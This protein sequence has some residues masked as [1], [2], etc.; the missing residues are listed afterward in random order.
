MNQPPN[1]SDMNCLDLAFFA[2]LQSL[3]YDT[4]CRNMD[5]LIS[6]V[7]QKFNEY[8]PK[9]LTRVF[10]TLQSCL[11]EVMKIRGSNRYKIPHMNKATLEALGTLPKRLS[12][13]R[14]LYH[15]CIQFLAS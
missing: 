14:Q 6:N 8:E 5:D 11:I 2:S 15:D 12:G 3:T 13:D 1:S 9:L 4:Y 10:L 7:V